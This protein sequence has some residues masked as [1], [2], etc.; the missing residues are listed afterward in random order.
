MSAASFGDRGKRGKGRERH[1]QGFITLLFA[2]LLLRLFFFQIAHWKHYLNLSDKNRIRLIPQEA[3]RGVIFDRNGRVLVENR[4]SYTISILPSR[5]VNIEKTVARLSNLLGI[6]ESDIWDK[7]NTQRLR[8]YEPVKVKRYASIEEIS[9]VEEHHLELP[10]VIYQIE[11]KRRYLY[12][13]V[14]SHVFGYVG[15]I[16]DKEF[17]KLTNNGYSLGDL[18]GKRGVENKYEEFLRGQKGVRYIEVNALGQEVRE[19]TDRSSKEL[20]PGTDLQLTLDLKL[21]LA[22]ESTFKEGVNGAIVAL[23]PRNGDVLALVSKPN[24]DPNIFAG[25]LTKDIWT[26]I[27][28][29][30]DRPL[31]N[32]AIQGRYP[33]GSTLKMVTAIAGLDLGLM[34]VN[35]HFVACGG[36]FYFGRFYGCWKRGGHGS[37]GI[38]DALI[39]SCD[40]FFYQAGLRV[41][42]G[43]WMSYMQRFG[44]GQ[45]T[46]IDLPNEAVGLVPSANYFDQRYGRRG[47]TKGLL[48][49]LAIGQGETLV[50]PIQMARYIAALANGGKLVEPHL[51]LKVGAPD[52]RNKNI[53]TK[54]AKDLG[55]PENTLKIV[56]NALLGV[57]ERGTGT[58]ARVQ[59]IQ[60]A[61]KT[62]TAQNPHG[63]DHSWFAAFAPYDNPTIAIAAIAENAGHGGSIAAPIVQKVL[64]AYFGYNVDIPMDVERPDSVVASERFSKT[65]PISLIRR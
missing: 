6:P 13:D 57:V 36:G 15:E 41:G 23:D 24:Y 54:P 42:L 14:G 37:L 52:N 29:N 43:N 61:G 44:F 45:R 31:L 40:T 49:N 51:L 64:S 17:S 53:I 35:T 8:P 34:D 21:Q 26:Q 62:G 59:K 5:Q 50:T 58:L 48:L 10:G 32:R 30:P 9:I 25:M 20:S 22:A 19:L 60:V 39:N 7:I 27:N 16:S 56:R 46:G 55:I 38:T 18:I 33:P 2:I 47:W 12:G 65:K 3:P 4:P 63:K 28:T 11:A 1:L